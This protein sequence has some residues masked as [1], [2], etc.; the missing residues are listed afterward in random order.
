[1]KEVD[2][3]TGEPSGCFGRRLV[4]GVQRR[5]STAAVAQASSHSSTLWFGRFGS[6]PTQIFHVTTAVTPRPLPGASSNTNPDSR[7][8]SFKFLSFCTLSALSLMILLVCSSLNLARKLRV[9]DGKRTVS[10]SATARRVQLAFWEN[11]KFQYSLDAIS[12]RLGRR[13]ADVMAGDVSSNSKSR[14]VSS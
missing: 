2:E 1:M 8:F 11:W 5:A 10:L 4:L 12:T 14:R 3:L 9:E 7:F 6:R 13:H